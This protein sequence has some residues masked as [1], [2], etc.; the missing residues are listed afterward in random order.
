MFITEFIRTTFKFVSLA[1]LFLLINCSGSPSGD[2][3]NSGAQSNASSTEQTVD[4]SNTTLNFSLTIEIDSPD[5]DLDFTI[6]LTDLYAMPMNINSGDISLKASDLESMI[7]RVCDVDSTETDCDTYTDAS[8]GMDLDF[9]IDSCGRLVDDEDCETD[10][11]EYTGEIYDDGSL[12]IDD[13]SIRVRTF[14]ITSDSDGYSAN[15]SDEG[16]I[17]INR[18]VIDLTTGE[19]AIGDLSAEGSAWDGDSVTLVSSGTI[20]STVDTLGGSDFISTLTGSFT[21][22]P[23]SL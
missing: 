2:S 18:L 4:S 8:A 21:V 9:V 13:L 6:A 10:Q 16:L 12:V 11:T 5:D 19:V 3:S 15:E 14:L 7:Y 22:D 17:V 23:L 1:A 20:S